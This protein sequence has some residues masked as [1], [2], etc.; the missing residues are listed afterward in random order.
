MARPTKLEL[1]ARIHDLEAVVSRGETAMAQAR[2]G[3]EMFDDV[4]ARRENTIGELSRSLQSEQV[5]HQE[6]RRILGELHRRAA[7][8]LSDQA[9]VLSGANPT[10]P[11]A[12]RN[13]LGGPSDYPMAS[14]EMTQHEAKSEAF[15]SARKG[16]AS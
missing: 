11:I 4:L 1:E 3:L 14:R 12:Q 10:T 13:T 2:E 6:T 5:E 7:T 8:A 16:G 9:F 15:V